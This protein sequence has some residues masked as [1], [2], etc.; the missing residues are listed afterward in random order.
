MV[1][2]PVRV[3]RQTFYQEIVPRRRADT[4]QLSLSERSALFFRM[5]PLVQIILPSCCDSRAGMPSRAYVGT[6]MHAAVTGTM[7]TSTQPEICKGIQFLADQGAPWTKRAAVAAPPLPRPMSSRSTKRSSSLNGLI[8]RAARS[9]RSPQP[10]DRAPIVVRR[11]S[12]TPREGEA[13]LPGLTTP[14]QSNSERTSPTRRQMRILPRRRR[15]RP[16]PRDHEVLPDLPHKNA[17]RVRL[18]HLPR[19]ALSSPQKP[20]NRGQRGRFPVAQY[21]EYTSG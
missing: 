4:P 13:R 6:L 16:A 1:R 20:Q 18:Q 12:R 8:A 9:P 10:G 15:S 11:V 2:Q 5:A 19:P 14:L 3:L 17:G 21:P 7:Q